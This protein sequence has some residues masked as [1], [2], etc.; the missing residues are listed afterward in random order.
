MTVGTGVIVGAGVG[1]ENATVGSYFYGLNE[2]TIIEQLKPIHE[3]ASMDDDEF[4]EEMPE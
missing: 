4:S 3:R 2:W 1:A